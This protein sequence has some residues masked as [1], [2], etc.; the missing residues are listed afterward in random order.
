MRRPARRGRCRSRGRRGSAGPRLAASLLRSPGWG[1]LPRWR[2]PRGTVLLR[3][4][5]RIG[6]EDEI[7]APAGAHGVGVRDPL[8][9]LLVPFAGRA[10]LVDALHGLKR[11]AEPFDA[12]WLP[13]PLDPDVHKAILWCPPKRRT[14]PGEPLC[15][16][17]S[18]A[19]WTI[20]RCG[21]NMSRSARSRTHSDTSS[22]PGVRE[23]RPLPRQHPASRPPRNPAWLIKSV[24][25]N[26]G[27]QQRL[28]S[29]AAVHCARQALIE[30][31]GEH[32]HA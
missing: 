20:G 5:S 21:S 31:P 19:T 8:A 3:R 9:L 7:S 28:F 4:D 18:T 30:Q 11:Q 32:L 24:A 6:G 29:A 14:L 27:T 10:R 16:P 22:V 15:Q 13:L 26:S 17:R 2:R 12:R 25:V 1:S 23:S